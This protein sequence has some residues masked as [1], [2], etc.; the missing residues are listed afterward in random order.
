MPQIFKI[1]LRYSGT[2]FIDNLASYA[3]ISQL[4]QN[5]EPNMSS[6][7]I[8]S[9]PLILTSYADRMNTKYNSTASHIVTPSKRWEVTYDSLTDYHQKLIDNMLQQ[10]IYEFQMRNPRF[11]S[12]SDLQLVESKESE[13]SNIAIDGSMQRMLDINWV[14]EL[15][16]RF[17]PTMIVPIQVYRPD[18]NKDEFLA[19]DGQHTLMLLWI[20]ATK[21]FKMK[22]SDIKIPVNVYSSNLKSEMR[23]NFVS[24]NSSEGKKRL[25]AIDIFQQ[26]VFGVR[27]DNSTNPEWRKAELKQQ[28]LEKNGL[29]VTAKKFGDEQMPGAISRLQEINKMAPVS[30]GWLARYLF[31]VANKRPIVEKEMVMMGHFFEKC[32]IANIKVD[33]AYIAKLAT[34]TKMLWKADFSPNSIF[35]TY[36]SIA[37]NNWYRSTGNTN[38]PRFNK[39]PPHGMPFF[40]AQLKKSFNEKIPANTSNSE[41]NPNP[42]DLF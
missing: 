36:A 39:E 27:V 35:W 10:A 34:L 13:M 7:F 22:E 41:F 26:Q 5:G 3:N 20:I 33:D 17:S 38:T 37:Y 6:A 29:F 18:P 31:H 30:V 8:S 12:W 2:F 23:A 15:L 14:L 28:H 1:L 42:A 9:S 4:E 32:F 16:T 19:W 21:I 24:L 25:E 11:K 40:L